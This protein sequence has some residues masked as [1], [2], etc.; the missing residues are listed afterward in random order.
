MKRM[1]YNPMC[2]QIMQILIPNIDTHG[3]IQ[4]HVYTDN[5]DIYT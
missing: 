4:T 3:Y 1:V 5:A 2:I